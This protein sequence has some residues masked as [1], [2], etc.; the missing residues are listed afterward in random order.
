M[1][2]K[3]YKALDIKLKAIREDSFMFLK[4]YSVYIAEYLLWVRYC[5]RLGDSKINET[6]QIVKMGQTTG[7]ALLHS[8]SFIYKVGVNRHGYFIKIKV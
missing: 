6:D 8:T 4:I 7:N 5:A 1:P 3:N 2:P